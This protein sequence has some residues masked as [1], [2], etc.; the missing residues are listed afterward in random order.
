M[1]LIIHSPKGKTIE[2]WIIQSAL[3]YNAD[4]VGIMANGKA[5][6]WKQ[7]D[8]ASIKQYVDSIRDQEFA[9]HFRMATDGRVTKENAHP[10]RLRNKTWLMHNGILRAYST[11]LKAEISDTRKFIDE[12]CNPRISQHGS[13]PVAELEKEIVGNRIAI[14]QTD[15]TINRYG[16]E[17]LEYDG[18]HYSNSYAWDMPGKYSGFS[19]G[20]AL[21]QRHCVSEDFETSPAF[22]ADQILFDRLSRV[23]DSLPLFDYGITAAG[24]YELQD[25]LMMGEIDEY[26]FLESCQSETLVNLYA[27]AIR[28]GEYMGE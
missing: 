12:F 23:L 5:E 3:E 6:K 26:A 2:K 20:S 28:A 8:A 10:F 7:L 18:N 19:M 27:A 17:W 13:I 14:M 24:D 16:D 1:C 25:A 22:E 11:G 15:G 9:I 4:G 21:A